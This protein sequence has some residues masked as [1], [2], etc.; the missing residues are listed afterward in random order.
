LVLL[1]TERRSE[2]NINLECREVAC[3]DENYVSGLCQMV[4]FCVVGVECREIVCENENCVSGLYQM[5]GF[6]VVGVEP[7]FL[8]TRK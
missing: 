2:D 8:I 3:E 6:C 4:G 1:K 5:V 7:T